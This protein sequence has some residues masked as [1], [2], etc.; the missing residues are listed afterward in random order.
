MSSFRYMLS[1]LWHYRRVHLA[2]LAGVVVATAV[3]TGALLVGDSVRGSLRD[4]TLERLGEIDS[5]LVAE[6]P[7]REALADQFAALTEVAPL[8]RVPGSLTAKSEDRSR[9]ATGL[10]VLGCT[11]EFWQFDRSPPPTPLAGNQVAIAESLARELGIT[12]GSEVLLRVPRVS[13]L[14]ADSTLGEKSETTTSRRMNVAAV[15]PDRGLA[16]FSLR[17]SQQPPRNIFVPLGTLQNLLDLPARVNALA[18]GPAADGTL[19]NSLR[20]TLDDFNIRIEQADSGI[21]SITAKRLVLPAA[22]VDDVRSALPQAKIQPVITYLANTIKAGNR[23]IPYSTICGARSLPQLGPL[24]DTAGEP[25][26]LADDECALNDWAAQDLGAKIGDLITISYYQ[27]E[28]THGQLQTAPPLELRL[29]AIAPLFGEDGEPTASND[30]RLAPRLP[31]VTDKRSIRNWELPFELVE[32][33]RTADEEYWDEYTTTPKA[34]VSYRLAARLWKTRWGTDSVLRIP[35]AEN[36]S[37]AKLRK[38]VAPNPSENGMV[39]VQVKV[40]GLAASRGTTA[41]E[42][43]FLG[44]SFFLMASAVMLIALLF[45]LGAEGRAAEVGLLS[46]VGISPA[47]VRR[48]WLGEA[49][50]VALLGALTGCAAGIGYARLMIHG[51]TTWWVAATVTPF[52]ELHV[53]MTSLILGF[54]VGASVA[55]LTIAWSLRKLLQLSA[56]QLLAGNC[57]AQSEIE[58]GKT[59]RSW[60]PIALFAAA[61]ALAWAALRQQGEAQAGA[62]FGSGALV[63]S[64]LLIQLT[65]RLRRSTAPPATLSLLGLSL[66][67]LSTRNARRHP[68]RTILSVALTAVASFLIVALSAFRLAPSEEGTGGFDVIATSDQSI[69]FDL[70]TAYGRESLGFGQRDEL[71][72]ANI[73]IHSFRVRAG[74]DASCLNLYQTLQPRVLGV[75]QSFYDH[76]QFAWEAVADKNIRNPWQLLDSTND[77]TNDLDDI[78]PVVLDKNTSTYSLHLGGVGA[79]LTIRDAAGRP[80]TL[81]VAGLLA[82]SVLQGNLLM[83]DANFLKLFPDTGGHQLFLMH[84]KGKQYMTGPL[85]VLLETQLEDYGFDANDAAEKLA[86]FLA[87]QNTYLSTFQS[88]GALGLLLGTLGLAVAQLRSVIERRGELALLRSTGFRRSRLATLVLSENGVLLLTGLGIGSAAALVAVLPHWLLNGATVPW[89][90]LALLL[91]TITA[92]GLAAGGLAVS[93][94]LEAPLLSALRGD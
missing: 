35:A 14:P 22:I 57:S 33:I 43:L 7:F 23:Q 12:V 83:S 32:P 53:S 41:F 15:L 80:V 68:G 38:C 10:S 49:V 45:R 51:L 88:L 92:A 25:I 39:L 94:A 48:L 87:V 75:P 90:T 9:H 1:S 58:G 76:N 17:P 52:L 6:Q 42:A 89:Q 74:E 36:V 40:Q 34:Y 37:P 78:V 62:F 26:R 82:G 46:A 65:G 19:K 20:P 70:N 13:S 61:F 69:H 16:G 86:N 56:Q 31:G 24:V 64:A 50:V 55:L 21:T 54:I 44:F 79:Q 66:L 93:A 47:N 4:L 91:A 5:V 67:G 85:T 27:P 71:A 28:T 11:P 77:G 2:V 30:P 3:V 63:L 29:R 72:L 73:E 60:L 8:L 81:R 59:A 84:S 18:L